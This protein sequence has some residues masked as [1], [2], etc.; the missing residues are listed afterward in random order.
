MVG[1]E[2]A[3]CGIVGIGT[4]LASVLAGRW[5]AADGAEVYSRDAGHPWEG[6]GQWGECEEEGKRFHLEDWP[7]A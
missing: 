1:V 7:V 2:G 3:Q 6:G 5:V 4:A